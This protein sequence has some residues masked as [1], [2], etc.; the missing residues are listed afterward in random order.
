[1]LM[2][3]NSV[4]AIHPLCPTPIP[5][6]KHPYAIETYDSTTEKEWAEWYGTLQ[7]V[8]LIVG[9][10]L[11]LLGFFFF[12]H[13]F[14]SFIPGLIPTLIAFAFGRHFWNRLKQ[15][16]V[17]REEHASIAEIFEKLPDEKKGPYPWLTA[18]YKYYEALQIKYADRQK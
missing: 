10:A 3:S 8:V 6:H 12:T 18:R 16:I 11:A 2:S 15:E 5:P 4:A 7:K 14:G 9:T 1:M 17:H 13:T